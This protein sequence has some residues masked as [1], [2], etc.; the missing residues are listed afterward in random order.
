VIDG[1]VEKAFDKE[2]VVEADYETPVRSFSST[3]GLSQSI[4]VDEIEEDLY[5]LSE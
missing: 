5:G 1:K 4:E 2:E 3:V